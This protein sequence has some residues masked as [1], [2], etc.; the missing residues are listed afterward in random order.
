MILVSCGARTE[1]SWCLETA[2]TGQNEECKEMATNLTPV[3]SFDTVITVPDAGDAVVASAGTGQIRQPFQAILNRTESNNDA[4]VA[5][6]VQNANVPQIGTFTDFLTP[7]SSA[8]PETP[9]DWNIIT[10]AV[11][12]SGWL[13]VDVTLLTSL[14]MD[15]T[16][17]MP[18]AGA[19]LDSVTVHLTGLDSGA[20]HAALP[21]TVPTI[22]LFRTTTAG[23]TTQIGVNEEDPSINVAAYEV[24]HVIEIN[25]TTQA[26]VMPHTI[27][28]STRYIVRIFGETGANSQDDAV[29]IY[30]VAIGWTP[31]T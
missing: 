27:L 17:Y 22:Q 6:A 30:N 28:A 3:S 10:S 16:P 25:S 5:L 4:L 18:V 29:K 19:T 13:Q 2:D 21:G 20:T 24:A 7:L 26:A 31:Q 14:D 9:A 1:I 8:Y 11:L 12:D 15:I 23:V